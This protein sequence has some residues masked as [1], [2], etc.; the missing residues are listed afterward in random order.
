MV[1][2]QTVNM[3]LMEYLADGHISHHGEG[4]VGKMRQWTVGNVEEIKEDIK[5]LQHHLWSSSLMGA[6]STE[7]HWWV[8]HGNCINMYKS[9]LCIMQ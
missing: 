8:C 9:H 4:G 7:C 3:E 5:C 6:T 2:L 1:C